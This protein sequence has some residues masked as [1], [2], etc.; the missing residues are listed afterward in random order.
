MG[1]VNKHKSHGKKWAA[2]DRKKF[3]NLSAKELRDK[4][5]G[6]GKWRQKE[7]SK[8][9]KDYAKK[10]TKQMKSKAK[11]HHEAD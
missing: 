10:A 2:N 3:K 5:Y 1:H 4:K 11:K 9:R 6:L 8:Y 7:Q